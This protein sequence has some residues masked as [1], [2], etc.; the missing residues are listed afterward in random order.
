[1]KKLVAL[2]AVLAIAG[3]AS[4]ASIPWSYDFE[5]DSA[6]RITPANGNHYGGGGGVLSGL[7]VGGPIGSQAQYGNGGGPFGGSGFAFTQTTGV[8]DL[9][10][11][12]NSGSRK[13]IFLEGDG[14][15]GDGD[16]VLMLT[17]YPSAYGTLNYNVK[18]NG[19]DTT[20]SV[21]QAPTHWWELHVNMDFGTNSML[22]E[23]YDVDDSLGTQIGGATT[24]YSGGIPFTSFSYFEGV[25]N[26]GATAIMDNLVVTPE[27]VTLSLLG[28]GVGLFLLRRRR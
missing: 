1:M 28:V 12:F 26:W 9:T 19:L 4:G 23:W 27:P 14:V 8:V 24:I 16:G 11:Q 17:V 10:C 15:H 6:E 22:A 25:Q 5:A 21:A 7:S 3:M 20:G 18:G 13:H 2:F